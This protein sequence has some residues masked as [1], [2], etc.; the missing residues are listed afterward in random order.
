M[1]FEWRISLRYLFSKRKE[2]FIS[3]IGGISVLGIIIGVMA[4]VV[5]IGVMSGFDKE[6]HDKIIGT[7]AHIVIEK[8]SGIT[9]YNDLIGKISSLKGISGVSA[10]VSGQLFLSTKDR[11]IGIALRGISIEQEAQTSK[12][13]DYM[14]SGDFNLPANDLL[15][16]SELARD[17]GIK[18]TDKIMLYSPVNK[19]SDVYS[20]RGIFRSGMYQYDASLVFIDLYRAQTLLGYGNKI[21]GISIRLKNIYDAQIIKNKIETLL[22]PE[23]II[24]S[25]QEVNRNYFAAL[26]LEKITMFIILTLIVLVACF[27]I[28]STLIVLVVDKTK[29]IGVLKSLGAT[30]KSIARIFTLQ[31]FL[32]GFFGIVVGISSGLVLCGLLKKYE[33]IKLPKDIYYL[34]HLPVEINFY[35]DIF[36][37]I[38][39]TIFIVLIATVY[40]AK[41]AARL[42]P[43][44]ALRYE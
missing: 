41:K 4:L 8:E 17:L 9:D 35:P 31:G 24:R 43:V 10:Y 19:T 5:V 30:K 29:D 21:S 37:I 38:I 28:I 44:E 11:I 40:P 33:F 14:I 26:K 7:T 3:L 34:D 25:W 23:F 22:G 20:V 13:R 6:L 42:D 39:A 27:N 15:V 16:G 32:V 18:I 36:A 12:I 1:S 2:K